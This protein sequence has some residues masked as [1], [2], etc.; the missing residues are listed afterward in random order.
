MSG[1]EGESL[2]TKRDVVEGEMPNVWSEWE[3]C[4]FGFSWISCWVWESEL[5]E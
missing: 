4:G 3:I 5:S 2:M 1:V